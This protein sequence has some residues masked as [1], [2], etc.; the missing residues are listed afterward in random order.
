MFDSIQGLVFDIQRFAI[1][2]GPGIRTTVFLKGCPLHCLWCHNPES[3]E[4]KP[5]IFFSPEK[6]IACRYCEQTCVRGNHH[7]EDGT[8]VFERANCIRC[9]DCTLECYTKALELSGRRLSVAVVLDEV[10]RDRDFYR[11]SGG[12]LTIS[13]GE[14]M[15]QFEFTSA[16]LRAAKQAELHNCLE[17][18][19]CSSWARYAEILPYVDLFLYD[20]KETDLALHRQ[21]TG[22][23]NQGIIENLLALDRAGAALTL[24]CPIIPGSNDRP[25][26]L[27]GIALLAEQLTRLVEIH[28][29]PYHVLGLSKSERL[30]KTPPL[31]DIPTPEAAQVRGWVEAIQEHTSAVVRKI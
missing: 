1:H 28:V 11:T 17:T 16:L 7:F 2:D 13:G 18:C 29:L 21:Y 3:Q 6:C 31:H 15:Q 27:R 10:L 8:H 9:G 24:R 12:G 23:S 25:D 30:G 14:P 5:E 4:A 20:V 26:H 22:V 19:G